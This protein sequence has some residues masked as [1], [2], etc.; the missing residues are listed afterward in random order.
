MMSKD[1]RAVQWY[2]VGSFGYTQLVDTTVSV[3]N[4]NVVMESVV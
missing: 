1:G 2:E 4:A 3:A